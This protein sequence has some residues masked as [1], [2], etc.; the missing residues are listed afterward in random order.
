MNPATLL[1]TLGGISLVAGA[2]FA[3]NV[4]GA[5]DAMERYAAANAEL[6]MHSRGE[7]GP[8]KRVMS[9]QVY[10]Y[11]GTVV[12]LGGLVLTLGGLLELAA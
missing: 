8:P 3:L 11:M 7:L 9:K 5:A 2:T 1:L 10:R 12:A 6:A 4:R